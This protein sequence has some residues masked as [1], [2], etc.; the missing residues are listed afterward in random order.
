[1]LYESAIIITTI[2]ATVNGNSLNLPF[3]SYGQNCVKDGIDVTYR[4]DKLKPGDEVLC[5]VDYRAEPY[6]GN[7]DVLVEKDKA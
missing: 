7:P 1:M 5:K 6:P 4:L 2:I 3:K